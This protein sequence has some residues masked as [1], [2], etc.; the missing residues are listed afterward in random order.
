MNIKKWIGKLRI[1]KRLR[2]MKAERYMFINELALR[3][4]DI[5]ILKEELITVAKE[6]ID[7]EAEFKKKIV[8]YTRELERQD[9]IIKELIERRDEFLIR[10]RA[11]VP[12]SVLT[13]RFEN[14]KFYLAEP[15]IRSKYDKTELPKEKEVFVDVPS[16]VEA[17]GKI[18]EDENEKKD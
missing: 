1:F 8:D 6:L 3:N 4:R 11:K 7:N 10:I 2:E 16:A 9:N 18:V 15:F 12:D 13:S 14:Y 17:I 5:K